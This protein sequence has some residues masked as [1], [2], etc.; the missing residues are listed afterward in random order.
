MRLMKPN[1][2]AT[3]LNQDVNLFNVQVSQYKKIFGKY[4]NWF[5]HS[6]ERGKTR[7]DSVL[8]KKKLELPSKI[9]LYSTNKL[10]YMLRATNH[11]DS[12]IARLMASKSKHFKNVNTW[13]MWLCKDLF[14]Q[15]QFSKS[16]TKPTLSTEFV[17]IGTKHLYLLRKWDKLD[18]VKEFD[19]Y[20]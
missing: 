16:I 20:D 4:P 9:A 12:D 11:N 3:E 19:Y 14:I 2:L 5:I 7:I 1:D 15:T 10:Y 17:K 6:A 18:L 13:T 8:Y